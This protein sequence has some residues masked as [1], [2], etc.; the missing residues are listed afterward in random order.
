MA[1]NKDRL[2]GNLSNVPAQQP[3]K[4]A[5][6][7]YPLSTQ[8]DSAVTQESEN[9]L[10]HNTTRTSPPESILAPPRERTNAL[11]HNSVSAK[12]EP[13]RVSRGYKL[14][15]DLIKSLKRIALE[16]DRLL[17]EVMEEAIEQYLERQK[18]G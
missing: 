2:M 1:S 16:D 11:S 6:T 14:R 17:Y 8:R 7:T 10:S 15:E 12:V 9:A 18:A 5:P 3:I 4:K 13:K